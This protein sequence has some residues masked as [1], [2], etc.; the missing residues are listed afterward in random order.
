MR[1]TQDSPDSPVTVEYWN[2]AM[3]ADT[4]AYFLKAVVSEEASDANPF[5]IMTLDTEA[6][7][8]QILPKCGFGGDRS[9]HVLM[10]GPFNIR[11]WST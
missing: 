4:G 5:G 3:A 8:R 9:L 6:Y 11:S 10:I 7:Q 2:G 1:A